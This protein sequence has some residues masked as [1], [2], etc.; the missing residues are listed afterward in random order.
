LGANKPTNMQRSS[1][2]QEAALVVNAVE[3]DGLQSARELRDKYAAKADWLLRLGKNASFYIAA[4][5]ALSKLIG[6]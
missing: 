1:A 6:A 3:S 4:V 5:G 2:V